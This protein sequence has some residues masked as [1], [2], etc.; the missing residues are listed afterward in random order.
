MSANIRE[1]RIA[2]SAQRQAALQTALTAAECVSFTKLNAA[3]S[4]VDMVTENDATEIGKGNEFAFNNYKSHWNVTGSFEKFI[5]SQFLAWVVAFGLGKT[6]KTTPAAGAFT[7]TC[8]PQDPVTDGIDMKAFTCV[9]AIRQGGSAVLDRALVGCVISDFTITLMSGPGRANAKVVANFMGCGRIVSPSTITVPNSLSEMFLNAASAAI[10]INGVNYVSSANFVML[11]Q[12]WNNSV[13]DA[14]GFYP[15][16]GVEQGAAIRGRMEFGDRVP[17]FRFQARFRNGS[18]EL[19]SLYAQTEGTVVWSLTGSL[20]AGSTN[21]GC[22]CTWHR[23]RFSSA[24]VNDTEG[25]VTVEVVVTPM[26]H[27]SNGLMTFAVTTTL[28]NILA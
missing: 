16:S 1:T 10:T 19:A 5:S 6:T 8:V 21:H 22:S 2:V 17:G 24:V 11:E 25:I 28:D 26:W 18:T 13:R 4:V 3:I 15:G 14:S 9:E 20:I 7:Y 23:M 12:T 27:T